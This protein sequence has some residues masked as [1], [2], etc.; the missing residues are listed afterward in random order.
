MT[1][2]LD[3]LTLS[4]RKLVFLAVAVSLV[5]LGAFS[6]R[7]TPSPPRTADAPPA[8]APPP[9]EKIVQEPVVVEGQ[10]AS[11]AALVLSDDDVAAA[12][13]VAER[14]AVEYATR[15]WDEPPPARLARMRELMSAELA[16]AF[17][18]DSGVAALEE[19]RRS[20]Q[21]VAGARPELAYPQTISR[22]KA[23]FTIVVLQTV[24]STIGTEER[25]PSYQVVVA[26]LEGGWRVV[27]LVA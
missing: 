15:R 18:T 24:S 13:A 27:D 8:P 14:F 1:Q 20:I 26:P 7:L 21:E 5:G 10:Q 19:E 12:Q 9:A 22:D 4:Q 16:A 17:S 11:E 25:R 2:W 6:F 23:I 3:R